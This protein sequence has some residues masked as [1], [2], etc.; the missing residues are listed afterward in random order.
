MRTYD[1]IVVGLGGMGSA[2]AYHLASRGQRVI[3]LERFEPVHNHGSSHGGSRI[4]RQSYFEDPAYVPLLLHAYELWD[5]LA[6]ET[7][8]DIITPTGGV[9]LGRPD[10]RT[11]AGS[12][13]AA[14]QWNLP[15]EVLDAAEIRARFPTLNPQNDEVGLFEAKAGF[16]RPEATVAAHLRLAQRHGADLRY[17]TP[18][19]RW[20]QHP[21]PA[22]RHRDSP[23]ASG[24]HGRLR[25][26]R[27]R[28]QVRPGR[29]RGARRPRHHR[30][31]SASH[32]PVRSAPTVP[33]A[34]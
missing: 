11:V 9:Y 8:Q 2:A 34:A 28:L 33:R 24:G 17:Q 13:R 19:L 14:R 16:V 3:G 18:V 29:R 6:Q 4:I 1:V 25:I 12:L 20:D 22:L 7:G 21:G 23:A 30:L 31:D 15:H 27:P 32:R 26:L 10:S 5:R